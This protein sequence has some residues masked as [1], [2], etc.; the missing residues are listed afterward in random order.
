MHD[1]TDRLKEHLLPNTACVI[2]PVGGT[3]YITH[4]ADMR[5][6]SASVIKLFLLSYALEH[7]DVNAT[8]R[9]CDKTHASALGELNLESA[10]LDT[11]LLMMIASS[12]NGATN[13]LIDRYDFDT[14]NAYIRSLKTK[15]TSINRKM[16][17]Y[18]AIDNGK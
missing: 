2:C 15:E 16:L 17:D 9:F 4:N 5:F 14:L 3:P 11:L 18:E 1:F 6:R 13:V 12:D 8:V 10:A 7:D